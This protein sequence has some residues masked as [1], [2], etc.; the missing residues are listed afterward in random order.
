MAGEVGRVDKKEG[1]NGEL[2]F[3]H[4]ERGGGG[5]TGGGNTYMYREGGQEGGAIGKG[6]FT[7][8]MPGWRYF[9]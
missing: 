8:G 6:D 4:V 3:L 9:S 1:G 5:G 2:G 7:D